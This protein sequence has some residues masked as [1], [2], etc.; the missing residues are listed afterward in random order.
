MNSI[1]IALE[2]SSPLKSKKKVNQDN[3]VDDEFI[4]RITKHAY[5]YI[6]NINLPASLSAEDLINQ[7]VII[8]LENQHKFNKN[9]PCVF[10][11]FIAPYIQ[12]EWSKYISRMYF[13]PSPSL[14]SYHKK[15]NNKLHDYGEVSIELF[16]N[17]NGEL[18]FENEK[19]TISLFFEIPIHESANVIKN[20]L[21]Q[22]RDKNDNGISFAKTRKKYH[23]EINIMGKKQF[24]GQFKTKKLA[25]LAKEKFLNDFM[26]CVLDAAVKE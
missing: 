4:K 24:I 9:I 23:L 5:A 6:R 15:K 2:N 19:D 26:E 22:L 18:P 8:A 17:E 25:I 1:L 3:Y 20:C 16:V 13:S 10:Y 11:T 7:G 14:K 12:G 21:Y